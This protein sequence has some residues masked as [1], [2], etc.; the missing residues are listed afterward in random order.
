MTE[1]KV[2]L[3]DKVM[4]NMVVGKVSS[5]GISSSFSSQV[6][7]DN[8]KL[9]NSMDFTVDGMSKTYQIIT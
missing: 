6:F 8:S 5:N 7:K 1:Q 3:I 2:Q 4:E 9:V